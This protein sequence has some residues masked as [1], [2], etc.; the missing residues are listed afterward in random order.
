MAERSDTSL[1]TMA[2]RR[3]VLLLAP[4]VILALF[5]QFTPLKQLLHPETVTEAVHSVR[6]AWWSPLMV[7]VVSAVGCV[8]MVPLTLIILVHGALFTFPM[9]VFVAVTSAM[10]GA[11]VMY[12]MGRRAGEGVVDRLLSPAL[13]D[14][15][16]DSGTK[17]VMGLAMLRW[18]PI[19]HFGLVNIALGALRVPLSRFMLSTLIG[20]MLPIL[21]LVVLG[22]RIRAGLLDPTLKTVGMVFGAM[23]S[24]IL[25]GFG[26]RI[27]ARWRKLRDLA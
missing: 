2:V 26:L 6:G 19:A 24:V 5:W 1:R 3:A 23:V 13:I 27:W 9:N 4:A 17:G 16:N 22:D 15:L 21:M 14:Q 25:L 12:F 10:V 8:V 18:V 11:F 7:V 20:Q